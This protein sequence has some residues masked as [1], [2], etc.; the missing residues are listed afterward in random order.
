MKIDLA[1][2][3]HL[4]HCSPSAVLATHSLQMPGFPYAT[5]VPL[6]CDE[7]Q[8]PLLLISALAEHTRN[9]LADPRCSLA[10]AA[11]DPENIQNAPRLTLVGNA[12]RFAP[13]AAVIART[14]RYLPAAEA[15]LE[16]DFMFFRIQVARARY[17]GGVGHMGWLDGP[18]WAASPQLGAEAE[19]ELLAQH[20]SGAGVRIL[21]VDPLGID[22]LAAGQRQRRSF[23]Q[24]APMEAIAAEVEALLQDGPGAES[25]ITLGGAR[26]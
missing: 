11:A 24:A 22:Y 4:L 25:A 16:L 1:P 21:G 12:E 20:P 2:A 13:S 7:A 3:L 23:V 5:T 15:Y 18:T 17:I 19:A 14:L 10:V 6:V 26:S 8:R 9:L